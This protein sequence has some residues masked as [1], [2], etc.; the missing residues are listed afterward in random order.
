[1]K[2]YP[3]LIQEARAAFEAESV[4]TNRSRLLLTAAVSA[5]EGTIKEGYDVPAFAR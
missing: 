3:A 2:N 4:R 5:G 1:M